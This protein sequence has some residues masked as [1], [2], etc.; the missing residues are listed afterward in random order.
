MTFD[1]LMR[2]CW[3][4]ATECSFAS[5]EQLQTRNPEFLVTPSPIQ[6]LPPRKREF[7]CKGCGTLT[8]DNTRHHPMPRAI[9]KTCVTIRLCLP[10]HA[11]IHHLPNSKLAEMSV[12]EQLRFIQDGILPPSTR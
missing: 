8:A 5:F 2:T 10:C 11:R 6:C 3:K 4:D 7:T 9:A 1:Q 12:E